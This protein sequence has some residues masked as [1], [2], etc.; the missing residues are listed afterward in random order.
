MQVKRNSVI[1]LIP[2][3][4]LIGCNNHKKIDTETLSKVYVD[5]MV[6]Q[7]IYLPNFDSLKIQKE[8]IFNKYGITEQ[9]YYYNLDSYK[10]DTETWNRFFASSLAYLDTLRKQNLK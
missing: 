4:L 5:I 8:K 9:D 10:A 7:E 2:V 3:L 1:F 6:A